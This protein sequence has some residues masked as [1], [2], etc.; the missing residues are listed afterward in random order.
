LKELR[1]EGYGVAKRDSS[2]LL[3][4][5]RSLVGRMTASVGMTARRAQGGDAGKSV[6]EAERMPSALMTAKAAA[7]K[8][9]A[10]H[11]ILFTN[12]ESSV[13]S[14]RSRAR[15]RQQIPHTFAEG[16]DGSG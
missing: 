5:S 16:A 1:P 4:D 14:R 2:S 11:L 9:A 3:G 6:A 15:P 13:G 7:L 8:A 12:H 10:L